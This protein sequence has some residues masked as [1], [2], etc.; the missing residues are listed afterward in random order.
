QKRLQS[1]EEVE[2]M[3][4]EIAQMKAELRGEIAEAQKKQKEY[5][6]TIRQ[7]NFDRDE[8]LRKEVKEK[9]AILTDEFKKGQVKNL[10]ETHER[11]EKI[12]V[13]FP[14]VVKFSGNGGDDKQYENL[15]AFT[16]AFPPGS[17]VFATNL[18]SDGIVQGG[19]NSKGDIPI[20]SGSMR[21]FVP[22]EQ[23]KPP[24]KTQNPLKKKNSN[25]NAEIIYDVKKDEIDLRGMTT[26][27][28]IEKLELT[29]DK[30]QAN[31]IERIKIIHGNGSD[32]LK[33]A[34]RSHLSRSVYIS[35]WQVSSPNEGG[36]GVTLA[37]L[38]AD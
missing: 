33:K 18:N 19:A 35:R 16:K 20:L 30:A 38:M 29:L 11:K 32:A 5:E 4:D 15:E 28:A 13:D 9:V 27:E 24:K 10:F 12:S 14:E 37:Y 23:L 21:L 22:W 17:V 31:Q 36:D 7:F 25:K 3:K 26:N 2:R 8:R 6:K 34:V 1:M